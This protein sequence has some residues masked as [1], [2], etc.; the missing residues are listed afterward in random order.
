MKK[1]STII[2]G[3][4]LLAAGNALAS[5]VTGV[6][7]SHVDG[8]TVAQVDVEGDVRFTHQT[9]VA[10]DGK[11]FRIII[12]ILAA[13]HE[14]GAKVFENLPNCKMIDIR[15]SQ[16]SVDPEKIVRLVFDMKGEST[17]RIDAESNSL[18]LYVTD[19]DAAPFPVW[20]SH[21]ILKGDLTTTVSESTQVETAQA[22]TTKP[23]STQAAP[24]T[25]AAN[26]PAS[27]IASI[28]KALDEDRLLSLGTEPAKEKE[29][30]KTETPDTNAKSVAAN[31]TVTKT[32]TIQKES[33]LAVLPESTGA[34][35]SSDTNVHNAES[36]GEAGDTNVKTE[37]LSTQQ[38]ESLAFAPLSLLTAD[39]L[40]NKDSINQTPTESTSAVSTQDTT[41][42]VSNPD[43]STLTTNLPAALVTKTDEEAK[44]NNEP[45]MKSMLPTP[46]N[47]TEPDKLAQSPAE[48]QTLAELG[49]DDQST[50]RF[51][52]D[53]IKSKKIKG[54]MVAEFPSRLVI[55]YEG[56]SYR[57]P[58][59]TLINESKVMHNPTET[60]V[61]NV[62]GL[63]LVG[64]LESFDQGNRALFEDKDSYGYI[65]KA[66]DKVQKGYVLRVDV[67]RVYFQIFEYGWSRTVA[68][69]M[70]IF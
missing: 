33:T 67:D 8:F 11:P 48:S 34:A 27:I 16:Y 46:P 51:R 5:R 58:F 14:M 36:T 66:G 42:T 20:S 45:V 26:D 53:P 32:D 2:I 43:Q 15:S 60:R 3:L 64:I 49:T 61:P 59:E 13:T 44:V 57:D 68:L 7:I 25:P 21:D 47:K 41:A 4:L 17:Y 1:L 29:K 28:N 63:K 56:K 39:E 70:E 54:T 50:A 9:E 40:S 22:E 38:A 65:L 69:D 19:P 35:V 6:N 62:E 55:K 12:D 52:R 37:A 31:D 24:A 18:K 23:E 30:E 10:K